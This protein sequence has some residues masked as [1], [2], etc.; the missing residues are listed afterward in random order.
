M[1][2]LTLILLFLFAAT[3]SYAQVYKWVDEKGIVHFTDDITQI[4]EKYW[5]AI[6]EVG[7]N[8]ENIATQE[9][10]GAPQKKQ[11]VTKTDW[12]E[13]K[14]TGKGEWKNRRKSYNPSRKGLRV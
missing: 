7:V 12:E 13:E 8:E 6:E 14:N 3:L 9:E 2:T 1:K 11:A 10:G 5:R 4:P